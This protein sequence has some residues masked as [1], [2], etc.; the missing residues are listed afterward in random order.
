MQVYQA[1]ELLAL[2]I[3]R[4]KASMAWYRAARARYRGEA[5]WG[6]VDAAEAKL[7]ELDVALREAYYRSDV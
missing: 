1:E 3:R 6:D 2:D 4:G 7:R 5:T